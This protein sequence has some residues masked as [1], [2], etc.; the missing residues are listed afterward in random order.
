MLTGNYGEAGAILHLRPEVPV[1][2]GHN[3]LWDLG[4]PPPQTD[5]VVAVGISEQDLGAWFA[6]CITVAT[7]D[8]EVGLDNEEQG[9]QVWRCAGPTTSWE[10]RWPDLRRRG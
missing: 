6:D 10:Q 7:I 9:E 2:S 4:P 3:S 1:Y 5:T 8:N